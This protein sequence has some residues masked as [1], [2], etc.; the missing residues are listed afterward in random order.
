[1]VQYGFPVPPAVPLER[2][3]CDP[4]ALVRDSIA[5]ERAAAAAAAEAGRQPEADGETEERVV[6]DLPKGA[7]R[8]EGE[9]TGAW[10]GRGEERVRLMNDLFM[11]AQERFA[12]EAGGDERQ[13][14]TRVSRWLCAGFWWCPA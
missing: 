3:L 9:D 13:F 2:P 11:S 5:V 14:E 4:D 7:E 10:G 12:R 6:G 1:M 8:Q